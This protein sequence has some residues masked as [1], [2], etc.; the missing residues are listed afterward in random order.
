M[1]PARE[2]G[3]VPAVPD[4]DVTFEPCT[5][6]ALGRVGAPPASSKEKKRRGRKSIPALPFP[7]GSWG[8]S[9]GG[10]RARR[11]PPVSAAVRLHDS[12]S[13]EGHHYLIFDL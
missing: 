6:G 13:E 5:T 12:I 8:V 7:A 3:Q 2:L 10:S 1:Q 4:L 11:N 9:A